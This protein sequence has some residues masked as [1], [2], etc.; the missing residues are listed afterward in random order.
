M[1]KALADCL[2]AFL[3]ISIGL[4][5]Q[6]SRINAILYYF[7]NIIAAAGSSKVS[8]DLRPSSLA[9]RVWCSP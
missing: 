2:R 7:N 4:F 3:A 5:N 6:L 9:A 1:R 8:A